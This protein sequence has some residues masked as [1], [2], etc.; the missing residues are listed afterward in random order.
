[1]NKNNQ[2]T[3]GPWEVGGV[4]EGGVRIW[5]AH[6]GP[7]IGLARKSANPAISQQ[8][9]MANARLLAAAPEL[10]EALKLLV[11]RAQEAGIGDD[12][13]PQDAFEAAKEAIAKAEGR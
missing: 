5:A 4:F 12:F 2:H 11:R 1:M 7:Y 3:K 6:G 8:E 10:L 13:W 9:A